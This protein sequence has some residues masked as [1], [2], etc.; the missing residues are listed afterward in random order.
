MLA[1]DN[2]PTLA[3]PALPGARSTYLKTAIAQ[4]NAALA[5]GKITPAQKQAL[6]GFLIDLQRATGDQ[7]AAAA[8][9]DQM[10]QSGATRGDATAGEAIARLKLDAAAAALQ[11]HDYVGTLA[12]IN[13][14]RAIFAEPKDQAQALFDI[15][16]AQ[17]G[18]ADANPA[19]ALWQDVAL[20]YMRIPANFPDDSL[21]PKALRAT[22]QIEQEKLSDP[23]AA[24]LLYQQIIAQYPSDPAAATA[25]QLLPP[26]V[27]S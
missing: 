22:A 14:N 15:A 5:D 24:G 7:K 6:S 8:T 9:A 21:A 17:A 2:P 4:V 3:K 16:E 12:Q 18:I 13:A 25:K 19:P 10:L 20:A 1:S 23:K 27:K 11:K 26:A